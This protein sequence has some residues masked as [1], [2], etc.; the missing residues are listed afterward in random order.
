MCSASD[1]F[2]PELRL[3]EDG[4]EEEQK[5]SPCEKEET[6]QTGVSQ[7]PADRH[8]ACF[9]GGSETAIPSAEVNREA[10]G[11]VG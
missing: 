4:Y 8:T 11:A 3:D 5:T 7:R 6:R 1:G 2:Y 9:C 10:S